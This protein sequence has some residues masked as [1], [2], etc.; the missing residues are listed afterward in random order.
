M[1]WCPNDQWRRFLAIL[2]R[3]TIW[4]WSYS[5]DIAVPS[6]NIYLYQKCSKK[7]LN[8]AWKSWLL[9]Q[10][11]QSEFFRIFH[12]NFWSSKKSDWILPEKV[13]GLFFV[14]ATE[15]ATDQAFV[16]LFV[17]WR[18][19]LLKKTIIVLLWLKKYPGKTRC[20]LF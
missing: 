2:H 19:L 1:F 17:S 6:Y 16:W 20:L 13:D 18:L 3:K 7:W 14:A 9:C 8:I 12:K 11:L 4:F 15:L 10:F 5:S